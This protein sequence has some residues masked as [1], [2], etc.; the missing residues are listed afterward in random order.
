MPYGQQGKVYSFTERHRWMLEARTLL[1]KNYYPRFAWE[2][3]WVFVSGNSRGSAHIQRDAHIDTIVR[4]NEQGETLTID[5]KLD[6]GNRS[7][8]FAETVSMKEYNKPGW[9]VPGVSQAD[10]LLWAFNMKRPPG[11]KVYTFRLKELI[12]WFWPRETTFREYPILNREN[13][14]RWTTIGRSVPISQI[15]KYCYLKDKEIVQAQLSL[16]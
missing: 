3:Q 10:A 8:I 11:L 15:P 13:G 1:D 6:S 9:M 2:G 12:D 14:K 5:E 16:F 7:T 4:I